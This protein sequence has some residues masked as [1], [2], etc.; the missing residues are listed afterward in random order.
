MHLT[1][2][3]R[4]RGGTSSHAEGA[5]FGSAASTRTMTGISTTPLKKTEA[6]PAT[7]MPI[8]LVAVRTRLNPA[9]STCLATAERRKSRDLRIKLTNMLSGC[10]GHPSHN[11]IDGKW[12]MRVAGRFLTVQLTRG[13][14]HCPQHQKPMRSSPS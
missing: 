2:D 5:M 7:S 1:Q 6:D 11:Q 14:W 8:R 12:G 13:K 3:V 10:S 4:T 9:R